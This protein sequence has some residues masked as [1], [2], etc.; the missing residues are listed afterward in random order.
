MGTQKPVE[1][2]SSLIIRF[3]EQLPCRTGP[4]T[5]HSRLNTEQNQKCLIEISRHRFSL[6]ISGLTKILQRVNEIV[7]SSPGQ[8]LISFPPVPLPLEEK[9]WQSGQ[10]T[11]A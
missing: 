2:V 8:K 3:E 10:P 9:Q 7:S 6:V 1:W 5:T 11:V 4:Q